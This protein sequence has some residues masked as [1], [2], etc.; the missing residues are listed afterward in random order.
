M[1]DMGY[2]SSP[3]A[4]GTKKNLQKHPVDRA[5]LQTIAVHK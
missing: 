4:S 5:F 3:A 1:N 2:Y